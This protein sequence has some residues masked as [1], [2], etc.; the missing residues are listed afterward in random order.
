MSLLIQLINRPLN[1]VSH[2]FF[3]LKLEP[4]VPQLDDKLAVDFKK[5]AQIIWD[6][7]LYIRLR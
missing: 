4:E 3:L 1:I 7:F 5:S 2:I 6:N